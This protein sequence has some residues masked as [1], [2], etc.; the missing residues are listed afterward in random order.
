MYII[1]YISWVFSITNCMETGYQQNFDYSEAE[2]S[3]VRTKMTAI[4]DYINSRELI[5][6]DFFSQIKEK[7]NAINKENSRQSTIFIT[8]LFQNIQSEQDE[9]YQS[10]EIKS[11]LLDWILANKAKKNKIQKILAPE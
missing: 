8:L 5:T 11:G 3:E 4:T 10:K 2:L 9:R 7:Y 6:Q 1:F